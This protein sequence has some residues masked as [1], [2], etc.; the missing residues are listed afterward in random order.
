MTP[1]WVSSALQTTWTPVAT[2]VPS[3]NWLLGPVA[4]C[5]HI[6]TLTSFH[7]WIHLAICHKT[8]KTPCEATPTTYMAVPH[9][10]LPPM[11]HQVLFH[12]FPIEGFQSIQ[13]NHDFTLR[14]ECHVNW[15]IHREQPSTPY[16]ANEEEAGSDVLLLRSDVFTWFSFHSLATRPCV[17]VCSRALQQCIFSVSEGSIAWM[18]SLYYR[19]CF[20]Q[21]F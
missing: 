13:S 14:L 3:C 15:G 12:A 5:R 7:S 2:R 10:D 11:Y 17:L 6:D 18:Y 8:L 1:S 9:P 21:Q 19:H 16:K 20:L 4:N